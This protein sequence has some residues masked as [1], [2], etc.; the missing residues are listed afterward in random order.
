MKIEDFEKG[1]GFKTDL[2]KLAI[3]AVDS[4]LK[5]RSWETV[6]TTRTVDEFLFGY[7]DPLL[8]TIHDIKPDLVPN[9]VFAFSVSITSLVL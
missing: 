2:L 9:P 7:E 8:K 1:S 6:F 4:F 3:A 5:H